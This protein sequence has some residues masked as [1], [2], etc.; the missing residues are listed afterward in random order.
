MPRTFDLAF[1]FALRKLLECFGYTIITADNGNNGLIE[2]EKNLSTR[3]F[4][5]DID[6]PLLDGFQFFQ[7][8]KQTRKKLSLVTF[9][10]R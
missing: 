9:L 7:H 3:I 4:I 1:Q 6:V 5:C 8:P 10:Q 2:Y